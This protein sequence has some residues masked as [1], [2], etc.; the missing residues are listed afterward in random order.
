MAGEA[1]GRESQNQFVEPQQI[2]FG[3]SGPWEGWRLG[4]RAFRVGKAGGWGGSRQGIVEA[5]QIDFGGSGPW[6]GWRLG[7]QGVPGR[8]K[9]GGWESPRR[10]SKIN[11]LR[12]NKLILVV[13]GR[14]K[15]RHRAGN[16][17]INLLS[18]NKL[19]LVVPGRG[20][21]GGWEAGRSGSWE[22]WRLGRES[23]I[24][25]IPCLLPP[26]PPALPRPGTTKINLL[27]LNKLI[28][29]SLP[30]ASPASSLAT[31][32]NHQNQFVEPQQ[33]DF[34]FPVCCLPSL[35]PCQG[36]EPPKSIC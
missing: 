14:G 17:K 18:L 29:D 6:E 28:L 32:R 30:A 19:L 8:G 25:W 34:G 15:G 5:Q 24:N 20:K 35:Q 31:A 33:I 11:L 1:P 9:A 23:K 27:S 12:L 10:E 26:Q 7:R 2:A 13:P 22:G 16:P 3:G 21:A 4:G 36:P